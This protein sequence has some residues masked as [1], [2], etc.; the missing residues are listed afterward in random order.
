LQVARGSGLRLPKL[1]VRAFE[2]DYRAALAAL[3]GS[4]RALE[5]NTSGWVPIDPNLLRWWRAEGG[6]A[7]SFGRDAHDPVSI[8]REFAAAAAMAQT[9]GFGPGSDGSG[10]W[11]LH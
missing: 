7:V 3:A 11:V 5:I 10:L 4:G 1:T 8:G 2:A 9:V 6:Q